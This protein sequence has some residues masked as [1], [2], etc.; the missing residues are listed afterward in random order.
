MFGYRTGDGEL[1]DNNV[2]HDLKTP[3]AL[4]GAY[5]RGV[6]DELDD[7]TLVEYDYPAAQENGAVGGERPA[8]FVADR[9]EEYLQEEV[10]LDRIPLG[11]RRN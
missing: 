5:G 7:G 6:R 10:A 3:I 8:D 1:L 2:A 11:H 9:A 4:I